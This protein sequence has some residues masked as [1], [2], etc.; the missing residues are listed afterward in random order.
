MHVEDDEIR[1]ELVEETGDFSRIPRSVHP[2]VA[3]P[4]QDTRQETNVGLL[5][6]YQENRC[7]ADFERG[8]GRGVGH[9]RSIGTERRRL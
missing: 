8:L 6:V 1:A 9:L 4:T 3:G 2:C 7:V 5:V